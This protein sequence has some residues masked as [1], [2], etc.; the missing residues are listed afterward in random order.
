MVGNHN[1]GKTS[2]L[3]RFVKNEQQ[4]PNTQVATIGYD[5]S[6]QMK[7]KIDNEPFTIKF[8]DTAGQERFNSL[9]NNYFQ[10]H[11]A[12]VVVFSMTDAKSLEGAMRWIKQIQEVKEQPPLIM[13]GN[14]AELE[15]FRILSDQH[16]ESIH[17]ST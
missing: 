14:K 8:G 6:Y 15:E 2:L 17:E 13:V 7:V 4:N 12:F 1:V 10:N 16:F 9:T 3:R 11:D 5:D